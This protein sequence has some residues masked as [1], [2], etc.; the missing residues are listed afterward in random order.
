MNYKVAL[1]DVDGTIINGNCTQIFIQYLFDEEIIHRTYFN[2]YYRILKQHLPLEENNPRIVKE[3]FAII[4]RL[5]LEEIRDAWNKCFSKLVINRYNDFIVRKI[6][7][8]QSKGAE[9]VLASGSPEILIRELATDLNIPK[10]NI[11]ATQ[12]QR[13]IDTNSSDH[14]FNYCTGY[15][16][17]SAVL[18][19]FNKRSIKINNVCF[20]TDNISDLHLLCMVGK[21]YWA[22]GAS[23]L[24]SSFL[25]TNGIELLFPVKSYPALDNESKIILDKYYF[26]KKTIIEDSINRIFPLKCNQQTINSIVGRSYTNWDLPTL[27]RSYFNPIN[28]YLKK[29][30]NRLVTL[31]TCAILEGNGV[32][33]NDVI[34]LLSIGEMLNL[35]NEVFI[36][37]TNWASGDDMYKFEQSHVDISILGNASISLL[38]LP[39]HNIIQN[40][41]N[42][43][44]GIKWKLYEMYT[45][46]VYDSLI[47]NG[48]KL[49]WE[50]QNENL[51][52]FKEYFKVAKLINGGFLRFGV[53]L[54][55]IFSKQD[56][57]IK[58]NNTFIDLSKNAAIL[59]QLIRDHI[60]FSK[61]KKNRRKRKN[62]F[63][64]FAN[65]ICIHACQFFNDPKLLNLNQSKGEV[66]EILLSANSVNYL[67]NQV[68]LY[69]KKSGLKYQ[70]ATLFKE[71]QKPG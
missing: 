49:Y 59:I 50:K 21:G 63:N 43:D 15:G 24:E 51:I 69:Q 14:T 19:L 30:N 67:E 48:I 45:S 65:F 4:S 41:P 53:N 31:G 44:P 42:L 9:I 71:I 16:K 17:E 52:S 18:D 10:D 58:L 57:N 25:S 27:E 5:R 29:Y 20:F 39:L 1:F 55:L 2:Q 12:L 33:L 36:D 35:S 66:N 3:A 6:R 46:L 38:S 62:K 61:W 64:L 54:L 56:I 70:I 60:A 34:S 32:N 11:I 13:S 47:G 40:K 23:K 68:K 22:G 7:K 26:E 28:E 8:F 37:I